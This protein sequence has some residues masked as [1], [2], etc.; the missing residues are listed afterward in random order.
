LSKLDDNNFIPLNNNEIVFISY[1]GYFLGVV[2]S[3]GKS[4]LLETEKEEIVLGTGKEDILCASSLIKDVKIKSIIKSNLYALREL[5]FPL[6]I[7]N[8]GHPASK[9]LKLVF[10]F[11]ERILLDSCIEA[12]THPD[13]H[14]L[15]SMEDLSGISIIA[16]QNGIE[17]FDP[18][19]RKIE[20]EKCDI[21]I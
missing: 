16:K 19:K 7:L 21:E 15:C 10:G 14:L 6:I 11:G 13:Q 8:K 4:F 20:F 1:N 5:S 9:R 3:L 12:G 2:K 18:K 17:V